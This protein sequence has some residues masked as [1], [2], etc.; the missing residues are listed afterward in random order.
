ML[1]E[2]IDFTDWGLSDEKIS[3][4]PIIVMMPFSAKLTIPK[5]ALEFTPIPIKAQFNAILSI[6]TALKTAT[7]PL[8]PNINEPTPVN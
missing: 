3:I 2:T 1:G 5:G 7:A 4:A 8:I 6:Y